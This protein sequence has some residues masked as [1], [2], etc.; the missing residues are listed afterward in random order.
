MIKDNA[1]DNHAFVLQYRKAINEYLQTKLELGALLGPFDHPPH[2]Q[3]TWSP[4]MTC[5]KGSGD[6]SYQICLLEITL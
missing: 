1:K 2:P 5:P 4:L 6:K 3:F